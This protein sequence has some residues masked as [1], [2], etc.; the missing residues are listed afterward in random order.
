VIY[1]EGQHTGF[2]WAVFMGGGSLA[3]IPPVEQPGFSEKASSMQ[4]AENPAKGVYM[5]KNSSGES[6]IWLS[7]D[8]SAEADLSLE[9]G[10]FVLYRIDPGTGKTIGKAQKL[11]GG[12]S[13]RLKASGKKPEIIFISR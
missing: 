4:P 7:G 8:S 2:A 9:K 11:S 1:S 6:I 3:P 12:K 13:V 5:L 10:S